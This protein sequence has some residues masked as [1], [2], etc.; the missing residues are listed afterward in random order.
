MKKLVLPLISVLLFFLLIAG[1][2]SNDVRNPQ[3]ATGLQKMI[4]KISENGWIYFKESFKIDP[5]EFFKNF[6]SELNLSKDD[7]MILAD[8]RHDSIYT[9]YEFKRFYKNIPV[10]EAG[11]TLKFS[12]LKFQ[13]GDQ[14]L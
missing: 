6:K 8:T 4:Q 1:E 5:N 11:F 12:E 14:H 10:L 3:L 2:T 13:S 7:E 9:F